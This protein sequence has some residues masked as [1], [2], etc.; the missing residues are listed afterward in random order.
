MN[1]GLDNTFGTNVACEAKYQTGQAI[2]GTLPTTD[3]GPLGVS[4][5]L[6]RKV[7]PDI[8]PGEITQLLEEQ[9]VKI[10]MLESGLAAL[11]KRLV[12]T[13][14][15]GAIASDKPP[16]A[17]SPRRRIRSQLGAGIENNNN[18]LDYLRSCVAEMLENLCL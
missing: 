11:G 3:P 6:N 13:F 18:K 7:E 9:K 12:P 16:Q 10:D 2:G 4:Q 14:D 1:Y 8:Q 15:Y 5:G 17:G